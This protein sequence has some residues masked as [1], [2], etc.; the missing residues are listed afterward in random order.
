MRFFDQIFFKFREIEK[1]DSISCR[2]E[3]WNT[4]LNDKSWM[5]DKKVITQMMQTLYEDE[6]DDSLEEFTVLRVS[7]DK[8][9]DEAEQQIISHRKFTTTHRMKYL[10]FCKCSHLLNQLKEHLRR[11][12]NGSKKMG[13][14]SSRR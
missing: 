4:L 14:T 12:M 6:P 2:N 10:H 5:Q 1:I 13:P 3:D 11:S 9:I 7:G 8:T